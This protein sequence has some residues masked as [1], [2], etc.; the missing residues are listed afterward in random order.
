MPW[1]E[2]ERNFFLPRVLWQGGQQCRQDRWRPSGFV[3]VSKVM[4]VVFLF[5]RD[6]RQRGAGA[7]RRHRRDVFLTSLRRRCFPLADSLAGWQDG[8]VLRSS[9]RVSTGHWLQRSAACRTE[10]SRKASRIAVRAVAWLSFPFSDGA[11]ARSHQQTQ[12]S[13]F[14]RESEEHGTMRRL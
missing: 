11:V 5:A 7:K 1:K 12:S 13:T 6:A 14:R 4:I 9:R 10:A 3:E 8:C 2:T